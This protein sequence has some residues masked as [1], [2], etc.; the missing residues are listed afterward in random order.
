MS[1]VT[2]QSYWVS[3]WQIGKVKQGKYYQK[4]MWGPVKKGKCNSGVHK[5]HV[6]SIHE[7]GLM[8]Q[9]VMGPMR[10]GQCNA[11]NHTGL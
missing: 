11:S 7:A 4:T 8:V 5:S 6:Y 10:V 1:Q 3:W 2:K 9:L